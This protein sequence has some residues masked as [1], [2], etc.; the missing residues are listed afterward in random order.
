MRTWLSNGQIE[1]CV[2]RHPRL[3][4]MIRIIDIDLDPVDQ[5]DP[6]LVSLDALGREFGIRSDER[7]MSVI[8]L[9]GISVSGDNRVLAPMNTPQVGL[10]DIR[11]QPDV[12]EIGKRDHGSP[13]S[14]YFSEFCLAHG[15]YTRRRRTQSGVVQVDARQA[16]GRAGLIHIGLRDGYVFLAAS[17]HGLTV[18][19]LRRF[20]NCLGSLQGG[21]GKVAILGRNLILGEESLRTIIV[22][23]LLFEIGFGIEHRLL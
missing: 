23:L 1:G 3:E 13:G 22:E 20:E 6:L 12:I 18:T 17:L 9:T 2:G 10:G 19:F 5:R 4:L 8:L 16:Q 14:N 15:N 7:D 21:C 11:A